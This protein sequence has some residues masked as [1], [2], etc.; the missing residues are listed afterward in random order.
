VEDFL[1]FIFAE[2]PDRHYP[3]LTP[4]VWRRPIQAADKWPYRVDRTAGFHQIRTGVALSLTGLHGVLPKK[5]F[6]ASILHCRSGRHSE[7]L[8]ALMTAFG[9]AE[10]GNEIVNVID[11]HILCSRRFPENVGKQGRGY[12]E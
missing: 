9:A 12:P 4:V 6:D 10:L 11:V 8:A 7:V 2:R 1:L 5:R 3:H